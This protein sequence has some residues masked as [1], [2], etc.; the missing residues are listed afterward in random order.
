ML[1]QQGTSREYIID[2]CRRVD[3]PDLAEAIEQGLASAYEIAVEM[4]WQ[5]RRILGTGSENQ[6]KARMWRLRKL[7]L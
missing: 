7:G 5:K 2:R 6:A 4:G 1:K 3:R